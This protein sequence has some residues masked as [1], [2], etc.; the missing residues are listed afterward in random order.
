M[1]KL[2][3]TLGNTGIRPNSFTSYALHALLKDNKFNVKLTAK[4]IFKGIL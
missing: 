4:K 1:E 3:S 2:I